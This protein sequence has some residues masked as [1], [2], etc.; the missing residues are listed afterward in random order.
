LPL[1]LSCDLA[2]GGVFTAG[3]MATTQHA[4]AAPASLDTYLAI[5]GP[6]PDV[7]WHYGAGSSQQA[8]LFLPKGKGPFP[9]ALLIH[10]GCW[11]SRYGGLLQ[12]RA[13]S[14]ALA[15][16]GIAA[17][18]IEYRRIDEPGG[19]YPGMYRDISA[20]IDTLVAHA[21][22]DAIDT[23]RVVAVGHSAGAQLALWAAARHRIPPGSPLA[24]KQP[25]R[26]PTV[27]SLG[28]LLDLQDDA[29]AITQSC[30]VPI[31][32]LTGPATAARPD[33]YADTSPASMLPTGVQTITING[34]EDGVAPPELASAFAEKA[35]R[36][37]DTVQTFV[38]PDA[39]HF[40]EVMTESPV[41]PTLLGEVRKALG[42][43]SR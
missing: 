6:R 11:I 31:A 40:D 18:N 3:M 17:L 4:L 22:D 23:R 36:A 16:Q 42:M 32:A 5:A 34:A 37:G 2:A 39:G 21:P 30:G 15:Q 27:I 41:W 38:I 28:G 24:V 19:G 43:A 14:S 8:E 1:L 9:I 26:I 7:T 13:L 29:D 10:G 20:A 12:F 35:R 33:V 25:L